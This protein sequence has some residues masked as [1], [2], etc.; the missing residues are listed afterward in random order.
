MEEKEEETGD[1]TTGISMTKGTT[2]PSAVC[3]IS[4]CV[5][6]YYSL[7]IYFLAAAFIFSCAFTTKSNPLIPS[8]YFCTLACLEKSNL[9]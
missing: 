8:K 7:L 1:K 9:R 2:T 5:L 6:H 4:P 3:F